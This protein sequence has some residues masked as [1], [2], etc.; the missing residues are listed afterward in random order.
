MMKKILAN[1]VFLLIGFTAFAQQLPTVAVATFDTMGGVSPDEAKVVTEL[2]MA[3]L[4]SKGTVNIVDRVN[5][6]KIIAEMKFQTSD[7]SDSQKTARLGA[8]LNAQYVIRGQLMKMGTVIYMT[9]TMIDINTAQVLYSAREQVSDLGEIFEKLPAYCSQILDKIPPINYFVGRWQS[10]SA[11]GDICILEFKI[12]GTITVEKF[13]SAY[14]DYKQSGSGTGSYSFDNNKVLIIVTL[15]G[16]NDRF[17]ALRANGQYSF[18][19]SKNSFELQ[20]GLLCRDGT[21]IDTINSAGYNYFV[22]IR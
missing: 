4:V 2:F 17:R 8:A 3:E 20:R 1:I 19:I 9:S 6:D 13:D 12:D 22:K 21:Y 10:S 14:D 15:S 18:D 5:F 7:W 16:L 11:K